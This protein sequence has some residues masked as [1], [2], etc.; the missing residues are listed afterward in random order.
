M[1]GATGY[2]LKAAGEI[3]PKKLCTSFLAPTKKRGVPPLL[4]YQ[5]SIGP[6]PPYNISPSSSFT[7]I[8]FLAE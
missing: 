5:S 1:R 7:P 4:F 8:F 2:V 6:D 3:S